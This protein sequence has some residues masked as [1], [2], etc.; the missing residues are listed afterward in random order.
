MNEINEPSALGFDTQTETFSTPSGFSVTIR[1]TNGQDDAIFSNLKDQRE[2]KALNNYLSNVI[3]DLDGNQTVKP[4][5]ILKLRVRDKYYILYKIR[6]LSL[7]DEVEWLHRFD[8]GEEVNMVENL[9]KYDWDYS[10]GMPPLKGEDGYN[11]LLAAKYNEEPY[12]R[13]KLSSGHI[14]QFNYMTGLEE[15]S[16]LGVN[17]DTLNINYRLIVRKFQLLQDIN[18]EQGSYIENFQMFPS[19]IMAEIR[20]RLDTYD[21]EFILRSNVEHPKTGVV[22]VISLF[23]VPDFFYPGA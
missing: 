23:A 5:D 13:F 11:P 16:V 14:V 4:N 21:S 2:Q 6:R 15:K 22:T 18:D 17:E 3:L 1:E 9:D 12:V 8:D 20:A 10:E 7:G 19:R